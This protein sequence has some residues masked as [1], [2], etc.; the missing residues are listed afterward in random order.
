MAKKKFDYAQK[1]VDSFNLFKKNWTLAVP[2][3]IK[4]ALGIIFVLVLFGIAGSMILIGGN[5]EAMVSYFT[6]Y[7]EDNLVQFVSTILIGVFVLL[8]ISTW[9]AAMKAVMCRDAVYS[10]KLKKGLWDYFLSSGKYFWRLVGI[11][12][13]MFLI[14]IALLILA[15]IGI[16][17][18]NI[19]L[20]VLGFLIAFVGLIALGLGVAFMMP[21]LVVKEKGVVDTLKLSWN[22]FVKNKW[23]VVLTLLMTAVIGIAG[24][25]VTE[26]FGSLSLTGVPTLFLIGVILGVI[27]TAIAE[28][29]VMLYLM[30]AYKR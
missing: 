8:V 1:L 16:A 3:L 13:L 14:A 12:I 28:V 7:F 11:L 9:L 5:E 22:F 20:M 17:I 30:F 29:L 4:G 18:Q 25:L 15:F 10:K 2:G 26:I 24:R 27:V 19:A 23:H 6:E 21:I